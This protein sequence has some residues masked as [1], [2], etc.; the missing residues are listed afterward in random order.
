MCHCISRY[1]KTCPFQ[2]TMQLLGSIPP[3]PCHSTVPSPPAY[4]NVLIPSCWGLPPAASWAT[5]SKG[6][7]ELGSMQPQQSLQGPTACLWWAALTCVLRHMVLELVYPLALVAT[8]WA[9]VLPLLFVDPH[10][11]LGTEQEG[12]VRRRLLSWECAG[13]ECQWIAL[14]SQTVRAKESCLPAWHIMGRGDAQQGRGETLILLSL[15]CPSG[16]G[17]AQGFSTQFSI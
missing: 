8:V 16:T 7:T 5:G 12:R 17:T 1:L 10:V 11:V 13:L 9:E 15:F 3:H 4:E 14:T 6:S 2:G